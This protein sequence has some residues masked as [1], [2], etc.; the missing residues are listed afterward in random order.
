VLAVRSLIGQAKNTKNEKRNKRI[1]LLYKNLEHASATYLSIE[2]LF[3]F[4]ESAFALIIGQLFI[5]YFDNGA[6]LLRPW[7]SFL[8][9]VLSIIWFLLVSL[10]LKNAQHMD[11]QIRE[12]HKRL[13]NELNGQRTTLEFFDPWVEPKE[14]KKW[15]WFGNIL[16]GNKPPK[17]ESSIKERFQMMLYFPIQLLGKEERK[18]T[19][20]GIINMSKSTWLLRRSLPAILT[21]VWMYLLFRDP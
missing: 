14:K 18:K 12:L 2:S 19:V 7:L 13:K 15:H 4:W 9:S 11:D 16:L 5:A 3:P 20:D 1:D 6:L 10:N 8:G 17:N 21:I